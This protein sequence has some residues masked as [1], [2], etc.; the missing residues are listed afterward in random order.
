MPVTMPDCSPDKFI[1]HERCFADLRIEFR[2]FRP[3]SEERDYGAA[4]LP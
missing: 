3:L 2:V 1:A 4:D